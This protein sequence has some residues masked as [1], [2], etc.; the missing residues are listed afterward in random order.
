MGQRQEKENDL[1]NSRKRLHLR[2]LLR[3]GQATRAAGDVV[4]RDRHRS[5]SFHQAVVTKLAQPL[6]G[7]LVAERLGGHLPRLGGRGFGL[8]QD[9]ALPEPNAAL[10]LERTRIWQGNQVKLRKGILQAKQGLITVERLDGQIHHLRPMLQPG[11]SQGI[12][13]R[14][15]LKLARFNVVNVANDKPMTYVDMGGVVV[16]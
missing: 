4:A 15:E 6:V 3:L 10:V 12:D 11:A 16:K 13:P 1:C 5:R 8:E 7:K 2:Q 9:E 14:W